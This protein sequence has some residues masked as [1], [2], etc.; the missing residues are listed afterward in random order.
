MQLLGILSLLLPLEVQHPHQ[1][2]LVEGETSDRRAFERNSSTFS[3]NHSKYPREASH[4]YAISRSSTPQWIDTGRRVTSSRS[5]HRRSPSRASAPQADMH[6]PANRS[7]AS[8]SSERTRTNC[9]ES[10]SR[11]PPSSPSMAAHDIPLETLAVVHEE[12][13]EALI[14]YTSCAD[15]S[16]QAARKERLRFAEEHGEIEQTSINI[17]IS[18]RNM[19][20]PSNQFETHV[21]TV[22]RPSS[23]E[24][25]TQDPSLQSTPRTSALER[26]G[27]PLDD[28]APPTANNTKISIKTVGK[29]PRIKKHHLKTSR[30][31]TYH[32]EKTEGISAQRFSKETWTN[33]GI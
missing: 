8:R 21:P 11:Q 2:P 23:L 16:E 33:N 25:V 28:Q 6:P 5:E 12:I 19:E 9:T 26:L 22:T 4:H 14:Q 17:A 1:A 10:Q 30:D 3:G 13:R 7:P 27:Q 31:L 20:G 15:P 29:T 32:W 24:R 18:N